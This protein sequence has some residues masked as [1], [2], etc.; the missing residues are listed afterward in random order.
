VFQSTLIDLVVE[1]VA[2]AVTAA[3]VERVID[4]DDTVT[5]V[6]ELA[7]VPSPIAPVSPRPQHLIEVSVNTAHEW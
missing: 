2:V 1:D 5:G 6:L 4:N 3:G 7:N